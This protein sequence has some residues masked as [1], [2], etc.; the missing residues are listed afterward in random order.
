MTPTQKYVNMNNCF[1]KL[2]DAIYETDVDEAD[3]D[4]IWG[5]NVEYALMVIIGYL[6]YYK[7]LN[8]TKS[9]LKGTVDEQQ[10]EEAR[11]A[12][13]KEFLDKL[14]KERTLPVSNMVPISNKDGTVEMNKNDPITYVEVGSEANSLPKRLEELMKAGVIDFKE[15][16]YHNAPNWP[17]V[18]MSEQGE[19]Q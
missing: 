10:S 18:I 5:K 13:S 15:P 7:E 4:P 1:C 2:R 9:H 12:F 11:V 3:E 19:K 8:K 14:A 6:D 16:I 17:K